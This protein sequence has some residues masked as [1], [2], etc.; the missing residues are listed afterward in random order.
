MAT[1]DPT[2]YSASGA[3]L[4][5]YNK[6]NLSNASPV[7]RY[8]AGGG[9]VDPYGTQ[10][11]GDVSPVVAAPALGTTPALTVPPTTPQTG[12]Q[13]TNEYLGSLNQSVKAG[14]DI[15]AQRTFELQKQ[16]DQG[17][18]DIVNAM[19]QLGQ[20]TA[21]RDQAYVDTGVDTTKQQ[22]DEIG[23]QIEAEQLAVRRQTDELKKNNPQGLFGGA[24]QDEV[25]RIERDS[26]SKQADLAIVQN[27]ALRKYS[28]MKDIADRQ[29]DAKLQPIKTNLEISKLFYEENKDN[30]T[31]E[32]DRMYQEKIKADDRKYAKIESEAKALA[33][34]KITALKSAAEQGAP[35]SVQRGIQEA[36]T[37]EE[38]ITAAGQY[39]GDLLERQLKQANLA[40]VYD[41]IRERRAKT[42]DIASGTLTEQQLKQVDASP[43]GKKLVSL[44]SLYSKSN[45]YKK[46]VDQ[47]GFKSSGSEKAMI[48]R[49]YADLQIAYKEAANLGALTGPDVGLIQNAI[50]PSSGAANYLDY[51]LS[52]GKAGVSGAIDTGISKARGE[53]LSNYKQLVSR[54]PSYAGSEYV[55]SLIAPF[56]RDYSAYKDI[57]EAKEGDIIQTEDGILLE[58][59]G[60]GQ[61]SPL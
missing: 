26:A 52:G 47:Y 10:K 42:A 16:K 54:N 5:P 44:S 3:V 4:D 30:L 57:N 31:K 22:V 43:Q 46:L 45:D 20:E 19:K 27:A 24:L 40:N 28:T 60:K 55:Q 51:R 41:Q 53:A 34:V 9:V 32:Q 14:A 25:N 8:N 39:G 49:A 11:V 2:K 56:S 29:V 13:G 6:A 1:L 7:K 17:Q 38:A 18:S 37:A 59:L 36:K 12:A 58:A 61:F 48:D 15:E 35:I 23:S 21:L 50:K 33:D